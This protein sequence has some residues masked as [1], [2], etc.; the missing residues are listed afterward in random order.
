MKKILFLLFF[1]SLCLGILFSGY[2]F[3]HSRA[4]IICISCMGLEED[5]E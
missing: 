2:E 1:L 3:I 4:S 5:E